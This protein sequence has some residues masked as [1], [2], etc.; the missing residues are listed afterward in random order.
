MCTENDSFEAVGLIQALCPVNYLAKVTY[1]L[2][3]LVITE[4][5]KAEEPLWGMEWQ[6]KEAQST[7]RIRNT[8]N[9]FWKNLQNVWGLF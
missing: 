4:I 2:V 7:K 1:L 3:Y 6:E 8:G 9:V 5:H